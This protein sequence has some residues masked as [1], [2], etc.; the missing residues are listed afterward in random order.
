VQRSGGGRIQSNCKERGRPAPR[1]SVVPAFA[2][3]PLAG[4]PVVEWPPVRRVTSRAGG[5][6]RDRTCPSNFRACS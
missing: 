1:P 6:P 4:T 2:R 3:L 5:A